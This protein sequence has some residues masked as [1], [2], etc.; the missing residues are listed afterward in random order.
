MTPPTESLPGQPFQ[1]VGT[2]SISYSVPGSQRLILKGPLPASLVV[3]H[4]WPRSPPAS[5][6]I[7]CLGFMT[8]HHGSTDRNGPKGCVSVNWMVDSLTTLMPSSLRKSDSIH[9]GP[10]LSLSVRTNDHRTASAVTGSP[11]WKRAFL[12]SRN[13]HVLPSAEVSHFSASHGTISPPGPTYFTSPSY[14]ACCIMRIDQSYL[15]LGSIVGTS[16]RPAKTR[17]FLSPTRS[18]ADAAD[19]AISTTRIESA[20]MKRRDAIMASPPRCA[21]DTMAPRHDDI[22][23]TPRQRGRDRG[24][25]D[26]RVDPR[27]R[28]RRQ[29]LP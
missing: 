24:A 3:S 1:Y 15:M 26:G 13:A 6:A 25:R 27:H 10:W 29:S 20:E 16:C 23:R 4:F 9:A 28:R 22:A 2:A 12:T 17:I 5:L 21:E 8:Y 11:E 18:N 7:T 19:A 14:S